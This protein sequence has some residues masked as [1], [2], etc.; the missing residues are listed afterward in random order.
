MVFLLFLTAS[1]LAPATTGAAG[2]APVAAAGD[3]PLRP[4]DLD[5]APEEAARKIAFY[6]RLTR[7]AVE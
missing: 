1:L 6:E 5:P 7:A 4:W 2:K 3:E